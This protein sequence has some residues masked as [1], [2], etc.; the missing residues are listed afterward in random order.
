MGGHSIGYDF[1]GWFVKE[2]R[3]NS[4]WSY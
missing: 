2:D 1:I 3:F 4:K